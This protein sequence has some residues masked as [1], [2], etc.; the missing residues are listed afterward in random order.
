MFFLCLLLLD[1]QPVHDTSMQD[2]SSSPHETSVMTDNAE[3]F[4]DSL[5]HLS[6]GREKAGSNLV[7]QLS[8]G[9]ETAGSDLV[10]QLSQRVETTE[11]VV[12]GKSPISSIKRGYMLK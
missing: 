7:S 8:H 11:C 12:S 2:S 3:F 5:S 4:N 9:R 10:S 1:E 6:Q